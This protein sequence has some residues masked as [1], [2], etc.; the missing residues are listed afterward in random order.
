MFQSNSICLILVPIAEGLSPIHCMFELCLNRLCGS[1][2]NLGS[3]RNRAPFCSRFGVHLGR[4]GISVHNYETFP[5]LYRAKQLC[6]AFWVQG[7]HVH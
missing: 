3:A 2:V 5:Q 4:G 6:Q 7:F 1:R